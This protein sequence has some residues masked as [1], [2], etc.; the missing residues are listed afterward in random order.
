MAAKNPF[1]GRRESA[2]KKVAKLEAKLC[3]AREALEIAADAE[4]AQAK[5]MAETVKT[6]KATS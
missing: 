2:E 4:R 3:A 5:L 1:T 6:E